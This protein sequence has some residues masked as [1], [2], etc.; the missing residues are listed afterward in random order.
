MQFFYRS[1]YLQYQWKLVEQIDNERLRFEF[2]TIR[3]MEVCA[4][5]HG[6]ATFERLI[7]SVRY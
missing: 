4:L 7:S 2:G 1:F 5:I 6:D 3:E